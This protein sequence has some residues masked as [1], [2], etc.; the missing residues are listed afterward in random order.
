MDRDKINNLNNKIQNLKE[1]IFNVSKD[2]G[3]N[4]IKSIEKEL[5]EIA[6]AELIKEKLSKARRVLKKD[7]AD[8]NEIKKHIIEA[9]DIFLLEKEWRQKAEVELLPHLVKFDNSIKTT[10]GLRQQ[11]KLTKEQAIY[12]AACR[13]IHKDISL[14]F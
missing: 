10:M 4:E 7:D 1:I 11:D 5:N 14:N 9:S 2:D 12:V 3:M 6:G 8:I 13:S